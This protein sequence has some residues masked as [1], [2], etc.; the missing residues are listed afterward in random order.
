MNAIGGRGCYLQLQSLQTPI[1]NSIK[2]HFVFSSYLSHLIIDLFKGKRL[3]ASATPLNKNSTKGTY[4]K[5]Y[6]LI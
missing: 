2:N 5:K 3:N 6:L 4:L 1:L